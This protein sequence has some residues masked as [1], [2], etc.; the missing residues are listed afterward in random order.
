MSFASWFQSRKR[1]PGRRHHRRQHARTGTRRRSFLPHLEILE[2]RTLLSTF[3]VLNLG[4]AGDDSLR[5]AVQAANQN[6]GADRIVFAPK[7]VGTITLSSQLS[8]TDDLKILGPG[9]DRVTVSGGGT[10]RVFEI[11]GE[12]PGDAVQ[13]LS[14]RCVLLTSKAIRRLTEPEH[15]GVR[16][17]V[18]RNGG[19]C[20]AGRRIQKP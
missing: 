14:C 13:D 16:R 5:A 15:A 8:V 10:T 12:T 3:H 11:S 19:R 2:D 17:I 7:L 4:D 6:L 1:G 18:Q 9:A 20:F